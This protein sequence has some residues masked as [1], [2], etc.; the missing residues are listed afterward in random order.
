IL[1][2]LLCRPKEAPVEP[3]PAHPIDQAEV[4]AHIQ[5]AV[6]C[7]TVTMSG[8]YAGRDEP[9]LAY[10]AFLE[11][12]YPLLHAKAERTIISGY[13]LVYYLEGTDP[14]LKPACFLSHQ[15]VVP[16][17]SVGWDYPP[18]GGEIH[19]G[20]VY[21]R[22]ALDM[23]NHMIALLEGVECLLREGKTFARSIYLC[24]G[25]DEE[26]STSLDGAPK[27]VEWLQAKGVKL[28]FVV[29]EGGSVIDGNQ[30][31]IPHPLAM[32]GASE[33]G[34]GDLEITV[35]KAGGHGATPQYPTA[36]GI[37]ADVIRKVEHK[38]MRAGW[39]PLAKVAFRQLAPH[40]TGIFKFFFANRD[41]FSPLL[42]KVLGLVAPMTNALIRTTLV[43]TVLTGAPARN[44]IPAEAKVNLNFRILTGETGEDVKRHLE[45]I[46]RKEIRKGWVRIDFLPYWDPCQESVVDCPAFET[47][48]QATRATFPDIVVA[49]YPIVAA[50]DSRFYRPICDCV[51]RF[52]PFLMSMDDQPRVHGYNERVRPEAMVQA[53]NWFANV[54]EASCK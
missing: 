3:A 17:P 10:R 24:F 54:I 15:D 38:P 35:R 19:D 40:A 39:T 47:I 45:K 44:I 37:L 36:D 2:T 9:F 42:L 11:K 16:A 51:Y 34:N 13:S 4:T 25:H 52:S 49:P 28:E 23:K 32:I 18:F 8:E 41:V 31:G 6:Q 5:A 48:K 53:A 7:P 46:L 21:G 50:T 26:V 14:A 12:A 29:D 30:L 27:I 33:K 1:R 20:F 22:G 43:P